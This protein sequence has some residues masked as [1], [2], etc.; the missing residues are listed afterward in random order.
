MAIT[1]LNNGL[2]IEALPLSVRLRKS[3]EFPMATHDAQVSLQAFSDLRSIIAALSRHLAADCHQSLV[4]AEDG[5]VMFSQQLSDSASGGCS[6]LWSTQQRIVSQHSARHDSR[7]PSD[8]T[9]PGTHHMHLQAEHSPC[10]QS[11]M[12]MPPTPP[13]IS[14]QGQQA[15]H[16]PGNMPTGQGQGSAGVQGELGPLVTPAAPSLLAP[17]VE[18]GARQ[19]AEYI[20][21]QLQLRGAVRIDALV[22]VRALSLG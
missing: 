17:D 22:Q 11:A 6:Q 2:D 9:L 4:P 16:I 15:G 1:L 13:H 5:P 10:R 14:H 21:R 20:G 12:L 7:L 3:H 19:R 18:L 8:G